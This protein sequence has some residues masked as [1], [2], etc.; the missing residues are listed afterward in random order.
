M[1][2]VIAVALVT[3]GCFAPS[4]PRG[5]PCGD[6]D[7]CPTGQVCLAGVCGG[8][9]VLGP[10]AA[11]EDA[12][13]DAPP[14]VPSDIAHLSLQ[15][16]QRLTGTRSLSLNVPR[17]FD[18]STLIATPAMPSSTT[19]FVTEQLAGGE[20]VVIDV[21]DL[22]ISSDLRVVGSR[23]LMFVAAGN[24]TITG[25][26]DAGGRGSAP[27]AGGYA[28]SLG[29]GAGGDGPE[30]L[31]QNAGGGGGGHATNGAAGGASSVIAAG[32][33]GVAYGDAMAT[34]LQGGS[35]GG[36]SFSS[37]GACGLGTGGGGGGAIQITANVI[38]LSGGIRVGGGGGLG[39]GLCGTRAGAGG[40]GGAGGLVFLQA[41]NLSGGGALS[42][43]GGGG[44][45]GGDWIESLAGTDGQDGPH[46]LSTPAL[47][48]AGGSRCGDGGN[49]G[50][51]DA[52]M[53]G[54]EPDAGY[55]SGGGG[56]GAAGRLVLKIP[57]DDT[58]AI[59]CV[60]GCVRGP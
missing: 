60:P 5:L 49:G 15:D 22:T 45:E 57:D 52:P 26:I 9:I 16:A 31:T 47:G 24:V 55:H 10:D 43:L 39:G 35:G 54:T 30:G 44:G 14:P 40:G 17:T 38:T 28:G 42:A 41:T 1:R 21:N 58:V 7:S 29:P 2:S 53:A 12:M 8:S 23:P 3:A 50:G 48:G 37:A 27:G 59:S 56:G 13:I 32:V 19:M 25:L 4:P 20:I 6:G 34:S 46:P 36:A 51:L 18:T 11:P 33:A